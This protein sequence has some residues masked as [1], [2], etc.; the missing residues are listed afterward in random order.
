MKTVKEVPAQGIPQALAKGHCPVCAILAEFQSHLLETAD[1]AAMVRMC[2]Y[3]AWALA[4]AAPAD[5]AARVLL[6]LVE[7]SPVSLGSS[8]A[9]NCEFCEKIHREEATR[10][11]E[12]ANH[13]R[14]STIRDWMNVQGSVCLMHANK[15]GE[16]LPADLRDLLSHIVNRNRVELKQELTALLEHLTHG[17]RT[18]WGVLGRAAEFLTSQRGITR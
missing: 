7:R 2:N 4:K 6:R 12:M 15:L 1:P 8:E 16:A 13:F 5:L 9:S 14:R 3:H 11:E 17:D 10:M 18:G